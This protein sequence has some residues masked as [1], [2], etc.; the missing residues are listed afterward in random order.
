MATIRKNNNSNTTTTSTPTSTGGDAFAAKFNQSAKENT[1]GFEPLPVGAWEALCSAG[2]TYEKDGKYGAWLEYTI[3]E[4]CAHQGKKGRSFFGLED[5]EGNVSVGAAILARALSDMGYLDLEV[6]I[7]SKKHLESI[8]EGI[9]KNPCWLVILV[10]VKKGY[11]NIKV[12]KIME[13][14]DDKPELS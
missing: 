8:L 6:G 5:E 13:N 2:G 7:K 3:T 12:Q 14:Q 11:T 1:N 10:A 9:Q 4:E